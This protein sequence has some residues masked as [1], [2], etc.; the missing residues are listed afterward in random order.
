MLR[1]LF[2]LLT[3]SSLSR[4][5]E[6]AQPQPL[7][8]IRSRIVFLGDSNTYAGTYISMLEAHLV[9]HP[10]LNYELLNLGLS[11]ENCVGSVGTRSSLSAAMRP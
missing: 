4:A 3:I 11:S 7:Q 2:I 6:V 8:G 10:Q 1:V 5:Q 9:S